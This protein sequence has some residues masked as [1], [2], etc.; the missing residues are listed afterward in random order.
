MEKYREFESIT[1]EFLDGKLVGL[2]V[3][4]DQEDKLHLI[5]S[6]KCNDYFT[7]DYE[8]EVNTLDHKV[9]FLSHGSHKIID[10]IRLNNDPKFDNAVTKY[11]FP[12][13]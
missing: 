7:L 6:Y 4:Y 13:H 9:S 1:K 11:F 2:N 3:D 12:T 10:K 8:L 5:V